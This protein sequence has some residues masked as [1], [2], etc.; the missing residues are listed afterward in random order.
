[1]T[2]AT[3]LLTEGNIQA[4]ALLH[5]ERQ[6]LGGI[7]IEELNRLVYA[8][9]LSSHAL[10]WQVSFERRHAYLSNFF[11]WCPSMFIVTKKEL[12]QCFMFV[13]F[14]LCGGMLSQDA[15]NQC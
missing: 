8:Q 3:E 14:D 10:T 15:G 13:S 1:M 2:H 6:K 12:M 4:E 9:V 11:N 7:C 5:E